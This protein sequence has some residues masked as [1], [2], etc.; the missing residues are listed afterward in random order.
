MFPQFTASITT[1]SNETWVYINAVCLTTAETKPYK[2][3]GTKMINI[4]VS[5]VDQFLSLSLKK[6]KCFFRLEF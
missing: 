2:S 3:D 1:T 5:F 6:K 4:M